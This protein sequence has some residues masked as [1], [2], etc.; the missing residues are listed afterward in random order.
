MAWR[1]IAALV[2]LVGLVSGGAEPARGHFLLNINVRVIHVQHL[3]DGLRIYLRLPMPYLVADRLGAEGP[4]GLPEPAPY[5]TN[6][7]E[8]GKL[9]H[10]LD[11]DALKADPEGLGRL[12]ADGHLVT[13]DG[14]PL[15][16][17]V[18]QV[19]AYPGTHQPPFASIDDARGSFDGDVYP[20]AF[21]VTYVGD[22][23]V[24]VILRYGNSSPVYDY[25]FS[26]S[27]DPGL[28]GQDETANLL[29][30][31]YAGETQVFR[32]RGLL[33]QPISIS[34]SAWAAAVTFVKEGVRHILEGWDHVLFVICLALGAA[35]LV[36]LLW[37]ATG[38]TIGHS[39]TL[40]AGFFG[41]VPSGAWFIPAVEM[42]I[43]LSIIYAALIAVT[44]RGGVARSEL[45]MFCITT[46][47]GLLHG[48]GFSFVLH[49]ILRVDSPDI[50]QSLLAFNV[51][52]ELGQVVIILLTWPLFRLVARRS[53]RAWR[54]SRWAIA[55]PC[56][57]IAAVWTGQRALMVLQA[58]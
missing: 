29:L 52:V 3:E 40:M 4:D 49:E 57:V 30:D 44:Q 50:W 45:S 23:V 58:L 34:R 32:A 38:F 48:L 51:G 7:M 20:D 43:A 1:V 25:A 15:A 55:I 6:R 22:T 36:S 54:V 56:I 28:P 14:T 42:G 19:R 41:Y 10:Y 27:L 46:A 24:D 53:D 2:L 5:T 26:S 13:V 17:E 16:V 18:E 39:V 8:D 35:S 21:P 11:A 33:E 37:R 9:V 12:V 31:H 47:I